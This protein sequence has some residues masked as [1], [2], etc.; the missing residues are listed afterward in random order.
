VEWLTAQLCAAQFIVYSL[1]GDML[2]EDRDAVLEEYCNFEASV[3]VTSDTLAGALD[4]HE[5]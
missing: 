4:M 2:Q 1:H 5:V 3:L